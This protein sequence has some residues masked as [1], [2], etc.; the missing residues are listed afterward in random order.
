MA[1]WISLRSVARPDGRDLVNAALVEYLLLKSKNIREYFS[2]R[3]FLNLKIAREYSNIQ[4]YLES[5]IKSK[6]IL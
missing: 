4:K 2:W 3:I 5:I 6:N 1:G